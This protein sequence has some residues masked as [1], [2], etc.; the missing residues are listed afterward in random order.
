MGR[1]PKGALLLAAEAKGSGQV[2]TPLGAILNAVGKYYLEV[3]ELRPL[4]GVT[5][6]RERIS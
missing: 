4:K 2:L 6:N 1:G 3:R 5:P